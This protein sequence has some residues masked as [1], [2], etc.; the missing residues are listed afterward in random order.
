[1]GRVVVCSEQDN[2]DNDDNISFS[3]VNFL[4][5]LIMRTVMLWLIL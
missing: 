5:T 2:N 3:S 4:T 1:M